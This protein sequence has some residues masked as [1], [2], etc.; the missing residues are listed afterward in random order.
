MEFK[1]ITSLTPPPPHTHG[2]VRRFNVYLRGFEQY[3][4]SRECIWT[5]G[6]QNEL[7]KI[8]SEGNGIYI[9]H[10]FGIGTEYMVNK[11]AKQASFHW[12]ELLYSSICVHGSDV[13]SLNESQD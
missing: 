8:I 2:V 3:H 10:K 13:Q 7:Y 11:P 5:F 6:P 9:N 1:I 4:T 12:L